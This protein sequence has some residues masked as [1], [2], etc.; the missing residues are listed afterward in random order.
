MSASRGLWRVPLP[1]LEQLLA[2]VESGRVGPP[3]SES[4]L[5]DAGFR[6]IA[7]DIMTAVDGIE[8]GG[9][10]AT[11]RAAIAERVHRQPPKLDLVW[12]G[13]ETK[14]SI[15]RS[16]ALVV[17]T[18]FRE[19][20]ET[21][22]VCGY[23]FDSPD[24]LEPLFAAMRDRR[25]DATFFVDIPHAK[26]EIAEGDA[27][28]TKIIDGFFRDVWT[29]GTPKPNVFYDPRTAV[30]GPPWSSL[31]AKCVIVDDERTLVTS[32]NFTNRAQTRNIEAGVLIEDRAFSS[33]LAA[34]WRQLVAEG[35]ARRY[36][37]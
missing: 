26:G 6:G 27:L 28:A 5:I 37:G 11:V 15:S 20:R 29:F 25:I 22:I 18:L 1:A 16:T 10:L 7:A 33:E 9:V 21:V 4:E 36:R 35:L 14:S 23:A 34:Q 8:R 30:R 17:E 12:T 19:A 2:T 24:I 31:H 3:F 13:P 32:A